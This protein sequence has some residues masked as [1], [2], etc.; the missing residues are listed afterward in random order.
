MTE[1]QLADRYCAT[2]VGDSDV[3]ADGEVLNRSLH[4]LFRLWGAIDIDGLGS[5][6][7]QA[8]D[9]SVPTPAV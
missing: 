9:I 5:L 7:V 4:Q 2:P 1:E 6:I 3:G 8:T